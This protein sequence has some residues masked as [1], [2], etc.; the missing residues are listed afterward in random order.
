MRGS[1]GSHEGA[2]LKGVT[3]CG[4]DESLVKNVT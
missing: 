3:K 4:L 1:N 2:D